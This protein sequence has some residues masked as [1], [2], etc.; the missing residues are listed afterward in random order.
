MSRHQKKWVHLHPSLFQAWE[1][2]NIE[3]A[4][5]FAEV[6]LESLVE[7]DTDPWC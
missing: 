1:D 5:D 3:K 7:Q 6:S 2:Y 4:N